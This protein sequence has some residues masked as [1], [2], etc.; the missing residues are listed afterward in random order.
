M[1]PDGVLNQYWKKSMQEELAAYYCGFYHPDEVAELGAAIEEQ[2]AKHDDYINQALIPIM[3]QHGWQRTT[4]GEWI[5]R[6]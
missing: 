5:K 6:G 3:G 2:R 1:M 4:S